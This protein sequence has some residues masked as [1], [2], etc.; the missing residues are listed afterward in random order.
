M[1]KFL[2]CELLKFHIWLRWIIHKSCQSLV[3]CGYFHMANHWKFHTEY[4]CDR[5]YIPSFLYLA[6]TYPHWNFKDFV[7]LTCSIPI[8]QTHNCGTEWELNLQVEPKP[9][10]KILCCNH[11]PTAPYFCQ[12]FT[13]EDIS[14]K[15]LNIFFKI[16]R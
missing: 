6:S 5:D 7:K 2:F 13:E 4:N 16:F 11:S 9:G 10:I 12:F 1:K 8:Y 15:A 3:W 14:K